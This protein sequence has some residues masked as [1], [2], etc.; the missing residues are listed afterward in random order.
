MKAYVAQVDENYGK[1]IEYYNKGIELSPGFSIVYNNSETNIV[2]LA[3][4]KTGRV[5]EGLFNE[6]FEKYK[7]A[8]EIK[9]NFY[10]AY[11]NWGTI[12]DILPKTKE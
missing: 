9:S 3:I 5:A 6:A 4:T 2:Y 11:N 7:K 10:F 1:A 8:I 12:R